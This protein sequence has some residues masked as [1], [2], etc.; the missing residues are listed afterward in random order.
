MHN[1]SWAQHFGELFGV[2][3]HNVPIGFLTVVDNT[4]SLFSSRPENELSSRG[5]LD[6]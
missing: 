2:P 1:I 5:I 6:R 4:A 3:T